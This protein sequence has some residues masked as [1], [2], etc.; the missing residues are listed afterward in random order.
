[1][2][3]LGGVNTFRRD[4]FVFFFDGLFGLVFEFGS[5]TSNVIHLISI[6]ILTKIL[7]WQSPTTVQSRNV[8]KFSFGK[9]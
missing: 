6:L 4:F 7:I 1:M 3:I 2:I 5:L 9:F 8:S